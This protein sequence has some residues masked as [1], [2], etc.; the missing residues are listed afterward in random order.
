MPLHP[1]VEGADE[2][3][4]HARQDLDEVGVRL[5]GRLAE[6]DL[7]G[8]LPRRLELVE[9]PADDATHDPPLD[10]R[11]LAR[12]LVEH[13]AP[14]EEL[15]DRVEDE[16]G[17]ELEDD[18]VA[19]PLRLADVERRRRRARGDVLR[20]EHLV[21]GRERDLDHR[22]ELGREVDREVACER[23]VDVL[24]HARLVLREQPG[25]LEVVRRDPDVVLRLELSLQSVEV[26][27]GL[28]LLVA[29]HGA[30]VEQ[31]IDL[32]LVELFGHEGVLR[33]A[34]GGSARSYWSMNW[35]K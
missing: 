28:V 24:E 27:R 16:A 30:D 29:H 6:L 26:E 21:H 4:L 25:P 14:A 3:R 1:D 20:V 18:L 32:V 17:V 35:V 15:L 34:L 31:G 33:S 22:P 13:A 9:G 11:H 12:D 19:E 5:E 8:L 23:L 7:V 2:R 10:L